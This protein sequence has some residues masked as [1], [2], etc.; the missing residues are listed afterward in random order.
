MEDCFICTKHVGK[1][2][3][4]GPFIY[5]DDYVY[6]GHIDH[7]GEPGYLGH[8]MIDLKRHAR[9]IGDM[10]L[11]EAQAFGAIMA[12]VSRALVN[13]EGAEHIY[14][15]VSGNSVSH[16]HMHLI[17]RYPGTP[18]EYWGAL[19]VYEWSEA[20]VGDT[21][22]IESLSIRIKSYLEDQQHE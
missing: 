14:S 10:N 3:T 7:N 17:P 1:I 16:L 6:V 13:S 9:L 2:E 12:R 15:L 19:E 8:I 20:P 4:A 21:A 11:A 18:K 5:E 22:D